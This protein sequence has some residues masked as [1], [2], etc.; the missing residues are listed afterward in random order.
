[1]IIMIIIII[2]IFIIIDII[3]IMVIVNI[4][5]HA[6]GASVRNLERVPRQA[7]EP[8]ASNVTAE[9][10]PVSRAPVLTVGG[11]TCLTLLV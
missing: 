3:I 7:G 6:F 5:G 10:P 2:I 8:R 11:T 9:V 1:M 4:H